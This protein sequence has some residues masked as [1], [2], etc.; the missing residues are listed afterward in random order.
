MT[1]ALVLASR[2]P[3][4]IDLLR[5]IGLDPL[6]DPADLD[7]TPLPGETPIG[8]VQRLA[9]AKAESV[10]SRHDTAAVTVLGADTTVDVD[11][12]ILGQPVDRADAEAMLR[13]LSGRTH[14]VHTA[15]AVIGGGAGPGAG[16]LRSVVVTTMVTCVP[17]T[18]ELCRWYLD[19]DEWRGKAGSYA[20]QGMGATLVD[21]VRGSYSNVVGLPLR[22]TARLLGWNPPAGLPESD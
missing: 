5:S 17:I 22:E 11:D 21:R 10:A 16:E 13:S 18:D 1:L 12:R 19:T 15:V 14:R 20:I 6:V 7:E 2:S 8:H 3:R 4:R 9:R